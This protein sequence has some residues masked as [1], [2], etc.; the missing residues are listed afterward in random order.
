VN[1]TTPTQSTV[2]TL[3]IWLWVFCFPSLFLVGYRRFGDTL[4]PTWWLAGPPAGSM[5]A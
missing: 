3:G 4:G 2:D 1:P 5:L